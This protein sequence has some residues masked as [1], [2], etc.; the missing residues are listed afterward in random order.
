MGARVISARAFKGAVSFLTRV[1]TGTGTTSPESMA[2]WVPYFPVVGALVGLS[3]ALAYAAATVVWVPIVAASVAVAIEV[4]ITGGFHEDGLGDG[5][6]ALGASDPEHARRI[7]KDPRL[8]S[9]GVLAL[10]LGVILRIGTLASLPAWS[11]IAVLPAAHALARAAAT[12]T[13]GSAP[14]AGEGLGAAY[15]RSL[16]SRTLVAG[17]AA[18]LAIAVV[19]IGLWAPVA[20]VAC[21]VIALSLRRA[22]TLR[23]GGVTG[24]VLGAIQQCALIAVL[25]L[26][27]AVETQGWAPL[28]WWR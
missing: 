18:A 22:A 7:L 6:D 20:A 9:F 28:A 23:L 16:S 26:A 27:S 5:A 19:A 25:L 15:A 12:A 21:A 4:V 14:I 17:A 2:T 3:G 1:P 10:I 8:G 24:D 13:L 11:A